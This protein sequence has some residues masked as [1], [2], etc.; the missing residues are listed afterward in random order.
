MDIIA[1]R[2]YSAVYPENTLLAF[3]KAYEAGAYGIELDA[4]LTTDNVVIVMHDSSVDRTTN[5]SGEVSA[6][7]YAEIQK[8]DAGI[9]K[10]IAFENEPVP[11]LE[12]V[13]QELGGKL[14]INIELANYETKGQDKLVDAVIELVAD[15]ELKDSVFLSSFKFKNLVR[16]KDLMPEVQCGLLALP[17]FKGWGARNILNHSINVDALHPHVSDI[18][19]KLIR[20]EHLSRRQVRVWT[21][22]ES[23]DMLRLQ[24]LGVDAIFTDDPVLGL[25]Y[26]DP[27]KDS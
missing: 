22:N 1:H 20:F 25:N 12:A 13:L 4:R 15:L 19:E 24:R 14:K 16:G 23:Q 10:G 11:T 17:G 7:T 6:M 18:S 9:H 2:G 8:L 3:R 27:Q 26:R 5:G 21:V